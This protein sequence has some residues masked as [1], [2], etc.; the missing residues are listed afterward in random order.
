VRLLSWAVVLNIATSPMLLC[1]GCS[2]G[3]GLSMAARTAAIATS[4]LVSLSIVLVV[5]QRSAGLL[6][7]LI[8]GVATTLVALDAVPRVA[9]GLHR[10]ELISAT[11]AVAAFPAGVLGTVAALAVFA[12]PIVRYLATAR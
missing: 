10:W 7:M 1:Y 9:A 6:L 12:R 2:D 4:A 11:T 5:L 3:V 8:A